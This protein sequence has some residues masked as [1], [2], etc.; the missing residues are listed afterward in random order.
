MPNEVG[1]QTKISRQSTDGTCWLPAASTKIQ[2]KKDVIVNSFFKTSQ[3]SN[4]VPQKNL[5]KVSEK[6]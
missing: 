5:I 4:T 6:L 3:M 2:E 1:G